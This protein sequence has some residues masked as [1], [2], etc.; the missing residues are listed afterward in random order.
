MLSRLGGLGHLPGILSDPAAKHLP[1][2]HQTGRG[3]AR[4]DRGDLL[5]LEINPNT[6]KISST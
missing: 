6:N 1:G 2:A 3:T 4:A 5:P